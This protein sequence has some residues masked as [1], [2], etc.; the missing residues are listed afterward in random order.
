MKKIHLYLLSFLAVIAAMFGACGQDVDNA[1]KQKETI[2]DVTFASV[3]FVY[4]GQE[5]EVTVSGE[6][7][8]SVSV[9][10][11]NN[12]KTDAGEY[13][14]SAVISGEGYETLTLE[15]T[16]KINKAK[17]AG[18]SLDAEQETNA[19]G[20]YHLPQYTGALP[21]GVTAKWYYEGN[22]L[23][24]GVK[25]H[26]KYNLTLVLSGDNYEEK[27]L[28]VLFSLRMTLEE[29]KAAAKEIVSSF[30]KTPQPWE[31]LPD[32][33]QP[34][35][36]LLTDAQAAAFAG[37]ET[38]EV[39]NAY[40]NFVNV[41]DIP[42]NYIGKQMNVVY[43]VLNSMQTALGYVQKAQA[44]LNALET[45]Y[46]EF[47]QK[48]P[49]NYSVFE[50]TEGSFKYRINISGRNYDLSVNVGN[51]GIRFFA[52]KTDETAPIYGAWVQLNPSTVLKYETT[53]EENLKIALVVAGSASAQV[54][55]VKKDGKTAGYIH[56]FLYAVDKQVTA[57]SALLT[58]SENYTAVVGT[59]GDF[60][61]TAGGRNCEVYSNA[62]GYLVGTEVK[63]TMKTT[64]G[65]S[66]VYDTL[67]YN[68]RD[69]SG[70]NS[71]KKEDNQNGS[72]PDTV[73]IN[74][75]AEAIGSME[76]DRLKLDFSRRFDIEFKTVYAWRKTV[77]ADGIEEYE[78]A[79]FE[80]PMLF[81]QEKC[82]DTF[83]EDFSK[84]NKDYLTGTVSLNVSA[85]D[86]QAVNAGYY[87]LLPAYEEI[88][89]SVTHG[90]IIDYCEIPVSGGEEGA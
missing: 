47:I 23:T 12:K 43:G 79:E 25:T 86:K 67:W 44:G 57:T 82:S 59:K 37:T 87:D 83:E 24:N 80:A 3:E 51:V 64:V 42:V 46:V 60:I 17:I 70:V 6:L 81:V 7:P 63:E 45:A 8:E 15:T 69:L 55:F 5:K 11:T 52:D 72:N 30:N 36:K 73:Y 13:R 74:G 35:Y 56:E 2:E 89:E 49:D 19:D 27:R 32:T 84:E 65:G 20:E 77:N 76:V 22:A 39:E 14:A 26:G 68:L 10:Y 54:E 50:D 29:I 4:D 38:Q 88:K 48:N 41:T 71:I 90:D 78:K 53:G 85:A 28:N 62:T 61:P 21:E 34:Q 9:A 66:G 1:R 40:E 58:V 75:Y 33:F 16:W 31:F 18:V